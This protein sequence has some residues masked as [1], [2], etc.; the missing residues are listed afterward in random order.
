[1]Q[2]TPPE[3]T[4]A[5][6]PASDA[7]TPDSTLPSSGPVVKLTI[8][9]PARRPRMRSG[10]RFQMVER[11]RPLIMSPPPATTRPRSATGGL[12]ATPKGMIPRPQM[13]AAA[14]SA[15]AG[16]GPRVAQAPDRPLNR[17]APARGADSRP[18]H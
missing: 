5:R 10:V 6:T 3:T 4:D 18:D 1:M 13:V 15:R 12:G 2:K 17:E 14:E 9:I 8:S 11:K 16:P 7:T